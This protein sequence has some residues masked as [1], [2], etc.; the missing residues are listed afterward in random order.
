MVVGIPVVCDFSLEHFGR[1]SQNERVIVP[2]ILLKLRG[3][4]LRPIFAKYAQPM[5]PIFHLQIGSH[6]CINNFCA[7]G[8][9]TARI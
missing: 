1:H 9:R 3:F 7:A 5:N 8:P 4:F 6:P 2:I